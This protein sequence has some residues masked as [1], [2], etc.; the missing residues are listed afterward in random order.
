MIRIARPSYAP[1]MR[2]QRGAVLYVALIMLVLLALIGI[3]G[4]QVAG[5]QERMAANY[6][7]VNLAFQS[8]EGV[9]RNA[10]CSI[11]SL[12]NR[13]DPPT[14]C[15]IITTSDIQHICDDGFDPGAWGDLQSLDSVPAFNV[16]QIDRCVQGEA[17]L[18]MGGTQ[19]ANP[20][21]MYQISA[22]AADDEDN[23]SSSAVVDTVFR[24]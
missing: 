5:M 19:D 18:D 11:E 22:Y 8:A 4:M 15:D 20:T 6:R 24:L 16:R 14:G 13:T 17:K 10:E 9:V 23:A 12:V 2:A 3:V 1:P 21:P 7:A